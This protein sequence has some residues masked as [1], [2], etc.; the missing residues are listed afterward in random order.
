[1][2]C[3]YSSKKLRNVIKCPSRQGTVLSS[4]RKKINKSYVVLDLVMIEFDQASKYILH[5]TE[6]AESDSH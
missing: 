5:V 4:T 6:T 2:T 1:M 3:S